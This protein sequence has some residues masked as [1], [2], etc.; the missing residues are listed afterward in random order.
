M[1]GG[2]GGG[3]GAERERTKR[4]R[5]KRTSHTVDPKKKK[6]VPTP[7]SKKG[8]SPEQGALAWRKISTEFGEGRRVRSEELAIKKHGRK[9]K[10]FGASALGVTRRRSEPK[11]R[12]PI[13]AQGIERWMHEQPL[14]ASRMHAIEPTGRERRHQKTRR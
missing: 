1:N 14:R 8:G 7:S 11:T 13:M 6:A 3:W 9:K 2:G 10:I 5:E 4:E 12:W